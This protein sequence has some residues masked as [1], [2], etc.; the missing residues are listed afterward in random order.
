MPHRSS[1]LLAS[2]VDL[3]LAVSQRE[4]HQRGTPKV[5][6]L[7]PAGEQLD[8]AIGRDTPAPP[9]SVALE[10]MFQSG[11]RLSDSA[12]AVLR[13]IGAEPGL[14]NNDIARR[15]GMTDENTMSQQLARLAHRGLVVNARTA[16]KY[17]VWHLTPAGEQLERAP[18]QETPPAEQ[19]RLALE[20]PRDR[21]GKKPTRSGKGG[22]R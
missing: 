3:G 9:R 15:V 2:L 17:N 18:W 11:G 1:R 22:R 8:S 10:L 12:V 20:L 13:V 4:A 14:S 5:W 7:T 19:H 16:G 6:L 21:G